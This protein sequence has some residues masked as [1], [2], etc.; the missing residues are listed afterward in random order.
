MASLHVKALEEALAVT[1]LV[2]STRALSLTEAG[3]A[4]HDEFK[5]VVRDMEG[6]FENIMH[7]GRRISGKLRISTTSEYGER[8]VLPLIPDF[9]AQHPGISVCYDVN[10]S[11]SDLLA[12]KLDLVVRLGNLADSS[13]RSRKLAQYD[14][15]LVASQAF[16]RQHPVRRPADLAARPGSPNLA[17]SSLQEPQAGAVRHRAG[18]VP[19]L[20]APASVRRP[21]DLAAAPWIANSNLSHPTGRCAAPTDSA[22]TSPDGCPQSNSSTAIRAMA[23]PGW[24][25]R[26]YPP[27]SSRTTWRAARCGGSCPAMPCR[28]NRSTWSFRTAVICRARRGR[29]SISVR[30]PGRGLSA[31]SARRGHGRPVKAHG[32][33]PVRPRRR[34]RR[35]PDV[36]P[37]TC[38]S[39]PPV[40]PWAAHSHSNTAAWAR[41]PV[42]SPATPAW[43]RPGTDCPSAQE[44]LVVARVAILGFR[45]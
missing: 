6:A 11:L 40:P 34:Q 39:C 7:Q 27:G 16:L 28:N 4:F 9:V 31:R 19:G 41:L 5:D 14:I 44:G 42:D 24:A 21:A 1:L 13:F 18:G 33:Q 8:F 30:A 32:A 45:F 2:R 15:V 38:G 20:P 12:E 17:D 10:A 23:R 35:I 25:W 22:W 29:S 26:C 3:K 36:F 43:H 37:R